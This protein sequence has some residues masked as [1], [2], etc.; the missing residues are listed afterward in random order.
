MNAL[1]AALATK[2]AAQLAQ[3][4]KKD[5]TVDYKEGIPLGTAVSTWLNDLANTFSSTVTLEI[6]AHDR[7]RTSRSIQVPL[8]GLVKT[9]KEEAAL[10]CNVSI[11]VASAR[12]TV[13][14]PDSD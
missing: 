11:G 3:A 12:V 8:M 7:D 9:K 5:M 14:A 2:L 4:L 6:C 1:N 10:L 13:T